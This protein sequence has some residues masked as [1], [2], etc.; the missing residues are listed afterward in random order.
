[1]G[2]IQCCGGMRK[3]ESYTLSPIDNY[4][5]AEMDFLQECPV[6]GHTVVQLTR[7]DFNGKVSECR[8]VNEKA[9]KFFEKLRHLIICS[10]KNSKNIYKGGSK[11]YLGYSE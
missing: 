8:K 3:S 5:L 2:F 6:C 4:M 1:M 7:I 11:F 9:R 10:G